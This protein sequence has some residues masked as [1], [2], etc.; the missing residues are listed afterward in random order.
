MVGSVTELESTLTVMQNDTASVMTGV[1]K[2]D[3]CVDTEGKYL[4]VRMGWK[5]AFSRAAGEAAGVM[6][7]SADSTKSASSAKRTQIE[8][9]DGYRKKSSLADDF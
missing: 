4:L 5:P 9:A 8:P 6:A 7:D 2:L 3:E 1:V